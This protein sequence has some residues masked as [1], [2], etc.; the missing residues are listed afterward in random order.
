MWKWY[1]KV[2]YE[3]D[4]EKAISKGGPTL[5]ACLRR[6]LVVTEHQLFGK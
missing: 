1:V 5:E 6:E 4:R 2:L 3:D